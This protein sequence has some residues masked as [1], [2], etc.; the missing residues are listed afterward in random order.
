MPGRFL[1]GVRCSQTEP[2]FQRF[3]LMQRLFRRLLRLLCRSDVGD[4]SHKF[5]FAR[6]ML[7]RLS[8]NMQVFDRI[9]PSQQTIFNIET[10]PLMGRIFDRLLY[11]N[12]IL[13]MNS[14]KHP[15]QR[16]LNGSIMFKDL[17]GFFRP[18]GFSAE[19]APAEGASM[20]DPL[21]LSQVSLAALQIRKER[22]VLERYCGLRSQ[23]M[24][25]GNPIRRE[26]AR[27]QIV[28]QIKCADELRLSDDGQAQDGPGALPLDIFV[29]GIHVAGRGIIEEHALLGADHVI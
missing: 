5:Q 10:C 7:E 2:I 19:N 9:V 15:L 21:P 4:G 13:G 18:I 3:N 22:C 12:S 11:T 14:F 17:E 27:G 23:Q 26:D 29:L 16:W 24:Q 28:L 1:H 20:A 8:Y 25:H 6:G